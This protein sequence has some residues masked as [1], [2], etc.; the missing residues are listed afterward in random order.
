V[1]C[2]LTDWQE[3]AT[4]GETNLR[5]PVDM[6]EELSFEVRSEEVK[7]EELEQRTQCFQDR[8]KIY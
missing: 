8:R 2:E 4:Y 5:R 7:P 3:V 1:S 6:Y